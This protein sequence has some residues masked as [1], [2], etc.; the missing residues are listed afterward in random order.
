MRATPH[1][2][3]WY[4]PASYGLAWLLGLAAALTTFP[5]SHILPN[6][7]H[8]LVGD[9]LQHAIGQIYFLHE[10]WGWPLLSV[11]SVMPPAGTSLIFFDAIPLLALPLKLLA[12]FLP[13]G[14]HGIGLWHAIAWSLQPV[15]AVYCLRGAG[16]RRLVPALAIAILSLSLPAWWWRFSHAA[17]TGHFLIL[18]ALG[19]YFRLLQGFLLRRWIAAAALAVAALLAH[20]Y[21]WLMVMALLGAAPL[22]L[23]CRRMLAGP[24]SGQGWL[25]ATAAMLVILALLGGLIG[26]LGYGGASPEFGY[27]R[28]ALN[29][30]SPFWPFRSGLLPEAWTAGQISLDRDAL[31]GGWE[32]YNWLGV[33]LFLGL[34]LGLATGWRQLG[35]GLRRHVGC[36]MALA[37]L[38]VLAVSM[39]VALGPWVL[40]DLGEPPALLAQFRASGRF[41]WPLSYALML[42]T[43]LLLARIRPIWLSTGLLALVAGLQAVDVAPFR[44]ELVQL[45]RRPPPA[46]GPEVAALRELIGQTR[47][48]TVL[49]SYPCLA[50]PDWALNSHLL[51]ELGAVAA[52]RLIP[53]NTFYLARSASY[54]CSAD[55]AVARRPL[56]PG[57]V[58][59]LLPA[60]PQSLADLVP[61]AGRLCRP[62]GRSVICSGGDGSDPEHPPLLV[63]GPITFA[64]G[65]AGSTALEDGWSWPETWGT[66]SEGGTATIL[67]TL[68]QAA[69][70]Q[71]LAIDAIGFGPQAGRPQPVTVLVNNREAARW[72]L[73][74]GAAVTHHVPV[75]AGGVTRIEFRPARPMSPRA[76]GMGTDPRRL[77]LGLVGLRAE[78]DDVSPR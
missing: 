49:P 28:Y 11:H 38:A 43:V 42:I 29:L 78:P 54:A 65:Q 36:W 47:T 16:E 12:P 19:L 21:L 64:A 30:L 45:A 68:P 6:G 72:E 25:P 63:T 24:S 13:P 37:V 75:P 55:A 9:M 4:G 40:L 15:A 77:G 69:M 62:A 32:G 44:H 52:P 27:G 22:T 10:P 57:E 1:G 35:G 20:P 33:G 41:F 46:P 66:W 7:T 73:P 51:L 17:L 61:G 71:R 26:A 53:L 58:R 18:L 60:A 50:G 39:R 34:I 76:R 31:G 48:L 56:A 3:A 8:G 67:L 14:F 70:P 23:I 74:D 5:L 2:P 59:V